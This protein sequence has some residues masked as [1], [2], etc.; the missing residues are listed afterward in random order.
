MD[1]CLSGRGPL[2]MEQLLQCT[3]RSLL[4]GASPRELETKRTQ[5]MPPLYARLVQRTLTANLREH[6]S[7]QSHVWLPRD[8]DPTYSPFL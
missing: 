2:A 4:P 7:L 8:D 5:L 1:Q 6:L 3:A